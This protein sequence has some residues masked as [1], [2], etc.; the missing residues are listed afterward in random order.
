MPN[1]FT[2]S[3]GGN[4]SFPEKPSPSTKPAL[5]T[6][7]QKAA[8]SGRIGEGEW[9]SGYG[10]QGDGIEVNTDA[11][12]GNKKLL[13]G[14][15]FV[16]QQMYKGSDLNPAAPADTDI[17]NVRSGDLG[18]EFGRGPLNTPLEIAGEHRTLG[19]WLPLGG[20]ASR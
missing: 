7:P 17:R 11:P 14:G 3:M 4:R 15:K 9:H 16:Q 18:P 6:I 8:P 13:D 20:K 2:Q 5:R 19:K 1:N 10:E 12:Y